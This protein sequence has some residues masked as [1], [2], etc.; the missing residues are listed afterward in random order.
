MANS[1]RAQT[2]DPCDTRIAY[3]K[4]VPDGIEIRGTDYGMRHGNAGNM[5]CVVKYWHERITHSCSVI[6]VDR[7]ARQIWLH[8]IAYRLGERAHSNPINVSWSEI[9]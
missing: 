3:I 5:A 8:Q 9:R 6:R 7:L 4:F 2:V 1:A